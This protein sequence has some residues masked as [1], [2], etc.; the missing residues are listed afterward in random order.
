MSDEEQSNDPSDPSALQRDIDRSAEAH[1]KQ[2]KRVHV[3]R[4]IPPELIYTFVVLLLLGLCIAMWTV[5]TVSKDAAE[6]YYNEP[7]WNM[8]PPQ[9]KEQPDFAVQ[10]QQLQQAAANTEKKGNAEHVA[11][12]LAIG[13]NYL[14][15]GRWD[16]A[17]QA[18]SDAHVALGPN[19]PD[20]NT[21]EA[22]DF[23]LG[24]A[25]LQMGK[26]EEAIQ[27]LQ[28]ANTK[29]DQ[30]A[31]SAGGRAAKGKILQDLVIAY[32]D[33]DNL[34]AAQTACTA[35]LQQLQES[36]LSSGDL[37]IWRCQ[38]ADISRRTGNFNAAE[39]L[40]IQALPQLKQRSS[41]DDIARARFG[42]ALAY[43]KAG[44]SQK[45]NE[46]FALALDAAEQSDGPRGPLL[47]SIKHA[48]A[49]SLWK[50]NWIAAAAM[51]FSAA[52]NESKDK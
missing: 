7:L 35:F 41:L 40:F 50:S 15:N 26:S 29:L 30:G 48:Y 36:G 46:N 28:K 23:G 44:D 34:E 45:A 42:L 47:R 24:H 49:Y 19:S 33:T 1:H 13:Q 39:R 10:E 37:T 25:Y 52:D 43:A 16:M 17:A 31:V 4:L 9:P 21:A 51:T 20:K 18:L 38:L 11:A 32:S 2:Y 8:R 12:L 3:R 22:I 27:W 5:R 14:T 6:R